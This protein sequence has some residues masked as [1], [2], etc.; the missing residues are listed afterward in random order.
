MIRTLARFERWY[1]TKCPPHRGKGPALRLLQKLVR[2]RLFVADLDEGFRL[3]VRT[4]DWVS[5]EMF[6]SRTW[7]QE[8]TLVLKAILASTHTFVDVGANIGYYAL[9]ASRLLRQGSVFA[10]EPVPTTFEWLQR[11]IQLNR[12]RN[13]ESFP[14]AVSD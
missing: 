13:I 14:V 4:D 1:T 9:L 2:G 10:Y 8:N 3:W 6:F 5:S 11:N 12:S 7:E